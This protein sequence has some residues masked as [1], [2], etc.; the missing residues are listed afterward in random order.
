[1]KPLKPKIKHFKGAEMTT[2]DLVWLGRM[3]IDYDI[4]ISGL[5]RKIGKAK[6]PERSYKA[7]IGS[8]ER[9]YKIHVIAKILVRTAKAAR[10]PT[11][12]LFE[13]C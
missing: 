6:I 4:G 5:V 1:M 13:I 12:I 11:D 8:R 2:I 3:L 9:S 10:P 7:I